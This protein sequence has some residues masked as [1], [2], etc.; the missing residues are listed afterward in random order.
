MSGPPGLPGE[1]G[2]TVYGRQ[3]EKGEMG[4]RGPPGL[5]GPGSMDKN[6]SVL[7]GP[8]GARGDRGSKVCRSWRRLT[9]RRLLELLR[10][11]QLPIQQR[12]QLKPTLH[13]FDLLWT[14][15]KSYNRLCNIVAWLCCWLL[16][17]FADLLCC[18]ACCTTN[19]RQVEVGGVWVSNAG[20]DVGSGCRRVVC[21]MPRVACMSVV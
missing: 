3:G 13:D 9:D 16:T 14:C 20:V 1:K 12:S 11:R 2:N 6:Q 5:P 17:F 18:T 7:V 15:S 19:P 4:L 21:G 10:R 8:A